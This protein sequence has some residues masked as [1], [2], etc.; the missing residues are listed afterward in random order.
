MWSKKTLQRL[1]SQCLRDDK[2]TKDKHQMQQ[3]NVKNVIKFHH[4]L[5]F[6]IYSFLFFRR[7][8]LNHATV[9]K[10]TPSNYFKSGFRLTQQV[11]SVVLC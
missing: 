11:T 6:C 5:T 2:Q 3:K 10:Q 7:T 9:D 8:A 4:V 1:F